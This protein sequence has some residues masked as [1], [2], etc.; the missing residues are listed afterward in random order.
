[1][2]LTPLQGWHRVG[3]IS[4]RVGSKS[5]LNGTRIVQH[6]RQFGAILRSV[7]Q[8]GIISKD[9]QPYCQGIADLWSQGKLCFWEVGSGKTLIS[10]LPTLLLYLLYI[11]IKKSEKKERE[12]KESAIYRNRKFITLGSAELSR[13][14]KI[15]T[16]PS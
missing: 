15:C 10:R 5:H 11:Y 3:I 1:M 14:V 8:N 2:S 16:F 13:S 7:A 4:P 12:R 6:Y 9:C